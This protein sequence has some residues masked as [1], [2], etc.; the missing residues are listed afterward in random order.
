[1]HI[2]PLPEKFGYGFTTRD[3]E[4]AK[5]ISADYNLIQ[6]GAYYNWHFTQNAWNWP[7]KEIEDGAD[8]IID[9]FSPNLNKRLHI[10]HLRNLVLANAYSHLFPKAKMVALLGKSL[11]VLDGAIEE[12]IEWCNFI[13]YH[14][15]I[16]YD[17][18]LCNTAI[19]NFDIYD[20]QGA[21]AGCKVWRGPEGP[22]ILIKSTGIP[23]YAFH[24]LLFQLQ[25]NP[26]HYLTGAEQHSHFK[27]LGLGHK[28]LPM[29]L[30]VGIDG[31]KIKSRDGN[32]KLAIE[33]L[34]DI[35]SN[36]EVRPNTNIKQLAWNILAMNFLLVN[37]TS[38]VQYKPKEWCQI[39][40]PGLTVSYAFARY[41][42]IIQR[43]SIP[44]VTKVDAEDIPLVAWAEY[45][46]Y[47]LNQTQLKLNT[48]PLTNYLLQL[49]RKMNA[50]YADRKILTGSDSL[51]MAANHM[52]C[53]LKQG[54]E[55][56]GLFTIDRI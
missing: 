40:S 45:L 47:Y 26:T 42:S 17:T 50:L 44:T 13:N 4:T 32:A 25:V 18:D 24:D 7:V 21:R 52:Y 46:H 12:F 48:P 23:T 55:S 8:Y 43:M 54:M 56:L 51:K 41:T 34:E 14:P 27:S 38:P 5:A 20:G 2:S 53:A 33:A 19:P 6:H 35:I 1:M 37:R 30:V 15:V 39:T 31:K 22:V 28:H 3:P 29:N 11:G 10:G 16:F 36:L 49:A 9:G